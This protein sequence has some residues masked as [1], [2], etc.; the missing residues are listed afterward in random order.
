LK[1]PCAKVQALDI[2][3]PQVSQTTEEWYR[4]VVYLAELAEA[5]QLYQAQQLVF[6]SENDSSS[7]K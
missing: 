3:Y 2:P 5:G 7:E 4:Y 1:R 6:P